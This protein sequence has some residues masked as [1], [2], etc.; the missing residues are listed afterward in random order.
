[1]HGV[2]GLTQKIWRMVYSGYCGS[3]FRKFDCT[4]RIEPY[5]AVLIG[6][7]NIEIGKN[8]YIGSNAEITVWR[9]PSYPDRVPEIIIGDNCVLQREVHLT[10]ID[11]IRIGNFVNM[12]RRV[13]ITDNSHGNMTLE[14]RKK[15]QKERPL[16]SK[17]PVVIADRVWIG[18]NACI[19][20]G[21]KVGEGAVIAAGA[22]VTKDVPPYCVAGGNPAR[23]IKDMRQ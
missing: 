17:G 14:D 6:E 21:V 5:A 20:P 7:E 2:V 16:V 13:T 11:S 19:L 3:R 18:Q 23:I 22:V 9:D 12:G 10:A 4:S 1:M 15:I 8:T